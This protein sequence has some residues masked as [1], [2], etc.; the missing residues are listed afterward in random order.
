MNMIRFVKVNRSNYVCGENIGMEEM[1]SSAEA[2][3]GKT[4]RVDGIASKVLKF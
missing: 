2:L 4:L 1:E 3:K